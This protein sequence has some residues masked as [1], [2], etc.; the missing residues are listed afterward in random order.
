MSEH[1]RLQQF[2]DDIP[3]GPDGMPA[4]TPEEW[5]FLQWA[6]R[7]EGRPLTEPEKRLWV[8]QARIIGDLRRR[9]S[10]LESDEASHLDPHFTSWVHSFV[11]KQGYAILRG[12]TSGSRPTPGTEPSH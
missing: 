6:E 11:R 9:C 4:W 12:S 3:E 8:A 5:E 2:V 7:Q 10:D 1:M